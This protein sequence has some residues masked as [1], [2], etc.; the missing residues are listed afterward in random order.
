M[1]K[2]M[3]SSVMAFALLCACSAFGQTADR[4]SSEY[5]QQKQA[6]L[7]TKKASQHAAQE[8]VHKMKMQQ[9][10]KRQGYKEVPG[11]KF[12]GDKAVD[13]ANYEKAKM[14]WKQ[15][16][17]AAYQQQLNAKNDGGPKR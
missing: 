14:E 10:Q 9:E 5:D 17:P 11:F 7:E 1:K 2:M 13:A 12:T 16:D 8:Q 15:K 4:P 6:Q 3:Q